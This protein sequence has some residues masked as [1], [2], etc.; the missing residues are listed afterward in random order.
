VAVTIAALTGCVGL[1]GRSLMRCVSWN[2][3]SGGE[4][5][6][7]AWTANLIRDT[8]DADVKTM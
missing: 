4:R 3:A 7:V 1:G 5:S 2:P 8:D 6:M